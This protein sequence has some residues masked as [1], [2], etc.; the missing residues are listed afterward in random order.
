MEQMRVRLQ[1]SL[2]IIAPTVRKKSQVARGQKRT[3]ATIL[4][5]D[6][7]RFQA[8]AAQS[9]IIDLTGLGAR[10]QRPPFQR[11]RA[12][13]QRCRMMGFPVQVLAY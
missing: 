4:P 9:D 5:T 12:F 1:S 7:E 6:G 10:L 8:H 2:K 11:R 13:P 3:L